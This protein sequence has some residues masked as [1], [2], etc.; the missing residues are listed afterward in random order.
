[1]KTFEESVLTLDYDKCGDVKKV[2]EEYFDVK[3]PFSE[4]KKHEF[5]DAFVLVGLEKLASELKTKIIILST[6]SDFGKYESKSLEKIEYKTYIDKLLSDEKKR[7]SINDC[8][9][10]EI[11]DIEREVKSVSIGILEDSMSY[12]FR[13]SNSVVDEVEV[14]GFTVDVNP[15]NFNIVRESDTE[16]EIE[17][18]W[19]V[20]YTVN[21]N[22]ENYDAASYDREDGVWYN[23]EHG[24]SSDLNESDIIVNLELSK[25]KESDEYIFDRIVDINTDELTD[26]ISELSFYAD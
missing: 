17:L 16:L 8:I 11:M 23:V 25:D 12:S 10:S 9:E 13:D 15:E 18:I 1:M 19:S 5:P 4:G 6:D 20:K 2:F 26:Y 21:I 7:N 24:V 22:F 3:A 14:E